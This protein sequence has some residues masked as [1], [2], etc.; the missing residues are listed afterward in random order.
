MWEKHLSPNMQGSQ[1]KPT[2][3][4]EPDKDVNWQVWQVGIKVKIVCPF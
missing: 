1:F 3:I 2:F 4:N